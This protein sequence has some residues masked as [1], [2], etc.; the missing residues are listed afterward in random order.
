MQHQITQLLTFDNSHHAVHT[1]HVIHQIKRSLQVQF[2]DVN[3]YLS[4]RYFLIPG[5]MEISCQGQAS[6]VCLC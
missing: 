3:K 5:G 2:K 1:E 6:Q 4:T